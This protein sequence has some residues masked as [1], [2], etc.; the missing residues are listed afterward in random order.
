[1]FSQYS[2]ST[3]PPPPPRLRSTLLS[4]SLTT[5]SI[6]E[7]PRPFIMRST[8][9]ATDLCTPATRPLRR[10]RISAAHTSAR[11][12][13]QAWRLPPSRRSSSRN[14][15]MSSARVRRS[16]RESGS[17]ISTGPRSSASRPE[18]STGSSSRCSPAATARSRR[19][20]ASTMSMFWAMRSTGRGRRSRRRI[21][22]RTRVWDWWNSSSLAS[23]SSYCAA[24]CS[25]EVSSLSRSISSL[26]RS[27]CSR[28]SRTRWI[29]SR[30]FTGSGASARRPS[31]RSLSAFF[32]HTKGAKRLRS[33]NGLSSTV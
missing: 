11:E 19:S 9:S 21:L 22:L 2:T 12:S 28:R 31:A 7:R 3:V 33:L 20:W 4:M 17:I 14:A 10:A 18:R 6:S 16:S 32:P 27:R 26:S 1:M 29:S 25:R 15:D 30:F 8:S 23:Q 13:H 24:S 5:P